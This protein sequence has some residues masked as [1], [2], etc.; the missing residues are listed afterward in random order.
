M[1]KSVEFFRHDLGRAELESVGETLDSVFL[2]LGP[3]VGEFE[4]RFA[5][6]LEAPHALG[7]LSCTAGLIL[8]LRALGVGPGD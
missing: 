6:Y 5:E 2:T 7:V 4:R 3:R 8:L 1:A